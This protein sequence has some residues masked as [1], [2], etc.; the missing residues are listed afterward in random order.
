MKKITLNSLGSLQNQ[1][2][3]DFGCGWG[4][5][6]RFWLKDLPGEQIWGVDCQEEAITLCRDNG[7]SVTLKHTPVIPPSGLPESHF[8]LVYAWSVFSHLSQQAADKWIGEFSRLL[9]PGGVLILTTRPRSFFVKVERMKQSGQVPE[10]ATRLY[11]QL[12]DN[13]EKYLKAYDKGEFLFLPTGGGP[14]LNKTF[15]GEAYV[16]KGYVE[17]QWTKNLELIDFFDTLSQSV[18]VLQKKTSVMVEA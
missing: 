13:I 9:K 5:I 4:R 17:K 2:I 16:S 1:H 3:M 18:I 14:N 12:S 8:G 10:W 11:G 7:L 15:Y 6:L